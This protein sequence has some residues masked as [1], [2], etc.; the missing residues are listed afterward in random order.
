MR[1]TILFLLLVNIINILVLTFT[2]Y[3][4][5]IAKIIK[6]VFS[7]PLINSFLKPNLT[8][9][10]YNYCVLSWSNYHKYLN[11]YLFWS[12]DINIFANKYKLYHQK[13]NLFE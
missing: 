8:G 9:L 6:T 4:I 5:N 12:L 1:L 13:F 10:L 3:I 7:F 11:I 2:L